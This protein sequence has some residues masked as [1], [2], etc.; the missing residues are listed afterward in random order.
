[1][2]Q[3]YKITVLSIIEGLYVAFSPLSPLSISLP[4]VSCYKCDYFHERLLLLEV[5]VCVFL[6][7]K[8]RCSAR[9]RNY[10]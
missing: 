4:N 9:D 6:C 5:G 2:Q 3:N 8:V 7:F 10:D 1:M